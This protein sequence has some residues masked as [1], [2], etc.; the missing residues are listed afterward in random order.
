MWGGGEHGAKFIDGK[1]L[2]VFADTRL[3]KDDRTV[4]IGV[5]HGGNN[6]KHRCEQKQKQQRQHNIQ[7]SFYNG[8]YDVV[9]LLAQFHFSMFEKRRIFCGIAWVNMKNLPIND[10]FFKKAG[11]T[12]QKNRR[13]LVH[14]TQKQTTAFVRNRAAIQIFLGSRKR[15]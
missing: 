3:T 1:A 11:F 15:C 8:I 5:D 4:G 10:K 7:Q 12:V 13:F 9:R 14:I 6:R 2:V